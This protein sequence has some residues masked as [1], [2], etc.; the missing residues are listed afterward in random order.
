MSR[1][2]MVAK[3]VL[4]VA[5]ARRKVA[6]NIIP[7]N[8]LPSC[9]P[10]FVYSARRKSVRKA[11]R[12]CCHQA[13]DRY[14]KGRL[15]V[16]SS[17]FSAAFGERL[18]DHVRHVHNFYCWL[19][20]ILILVDW[21][22]E[23]LLHA[24]RRNGVASTEINVVSAVVNEGVVQRHHRVAVEK[25]SGPAKDKIC[26]DTVECWRVQ[27]FHNAPCIHVE[28]PQT[29]DDRRKLIVCPIIIRVGRQ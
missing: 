12:R 14:W 4:S 1:N 17:L 16:A 10:H 8:E 2:K 29:S 26:R 19:A 9:L 11:V 23:G 27:W 5:S 13:M 24:D 21:A 25:V 22:G 18:V 7:M 3:G 20:S 6:L 28:I 15:G